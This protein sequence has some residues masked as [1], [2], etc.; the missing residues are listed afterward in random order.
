MG[1]VIGIKTV[2]YVNKKNNERVQGVELHMQKLLQDGEGYEVSKC[3]VPLT[4][5]PDICNNV[6]LGSNVMV[7]FNR[8]GQVDDIII[9]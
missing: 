3:Y 5:F 9:I 8:W 4:K 2:D 7:S 1:V 6:A